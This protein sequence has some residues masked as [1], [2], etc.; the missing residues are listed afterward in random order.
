MML[1]FILQNLF[2]F[3]CAFI[4]M[5]D[6]V[7]QSEVSIPFLSFVLLCI[8]LQRGVFCVS[9][10]RCEAF[11][12][13]LSPDPP[14][15]P[16]RSVFSFFSFLFLYQRF[17]TRCVLYPR[18]FIHLLFWSVIFP[19]PLFPFEKTSFGHDVRLFVGADLFNGFLLTFFLVQCLIFE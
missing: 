14:R 10:S 8:S 7:G 16:V 5:S 2:F 9:L 6:V 4:R 3:F 13:P 12:F 19:T 15:F 11:F 1:R 18:G 17:K